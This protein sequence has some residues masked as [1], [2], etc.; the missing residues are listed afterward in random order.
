MLIGPA[1]ARVC[2]RPR[3]PPD[4]STSE[5]QHF[6]WGPFRAAAFTLYLR[7]GANSAAAGEQRRL[8]GASGTERSFPRRAPGVTL[9]VPPVFIE[10]GG[11]KGC[12]GSQTRPVRSRGC[13][14]IGSS[15]VPRASRDAT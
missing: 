1:A 3:C 13:S 2:Y 4:R 11:G 10:S 8:I 15:V 12:V 6:V 7:G 5:K 9:N 14:F